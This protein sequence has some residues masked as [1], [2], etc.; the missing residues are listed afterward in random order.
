MITYSIHTRTK[1]NKRKPIVQVTGFVPIPWTVSSKMDEK[2]QHRGRKYDLAF[3][4]GLKIDSYAIQ[5]V[6]LMICGT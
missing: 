2:M 4:F 6:K 5:C 1:I 3:A